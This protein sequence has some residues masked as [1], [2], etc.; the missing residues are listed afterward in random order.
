VGAAL[1]A[2]IGRAHGDVATATRTNTETV[3]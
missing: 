1:A 3:F 2:A